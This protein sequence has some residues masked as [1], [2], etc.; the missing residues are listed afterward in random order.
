MSHIPQDT[1]LARFTKISRDLIDAAMAA[2]TGA[3]KLASAISD[4]ERGPDW[5]LPRMQKCIDQFTAPAERWRDDA[6][7]PMMLTMIG[8]ARGKADVEAV[9]WI[10]APTAHAIAYGLAHFYADRF[11]WL[12][13]IPMATQPGPSKSQ[14][15]IQCR[16]F[17][18][19]VGELPAWSEQ[20]LK[21][22]IEAEFNATAAMMLRRK[23]KAAPAI[24][25]VFDADSRELSISGKV[26]KRYKRPAENQI[27]VLTAFQESGWPS[28]IDNP[29]PPKKNLRETIRSFNKT[30]GICI[31]LG[32]DSGNGI[33]WARL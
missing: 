16:A 3:T 9:G 7:R 1:E 4:K 32:S 22:K 2:R 13:T 14:R 20:E 23:Q 8:I 30:A 28:R 17:V 12:V 31:K 24:K 27:L 18:D 25:P 15:A 29:L 6:G 10:V 5:F 21:A 33:R 19:A 11:A 26:I